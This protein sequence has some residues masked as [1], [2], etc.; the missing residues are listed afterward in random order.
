MTHETIRSFVRVFG[1]FL[2]VA[3]ICVALV[4]GATEVA[5]AQ[6]AT[7]PTSTD[8]IE[9][10][11][12]MVA[13]P[14]AETTPA[15]ERAED[16][17]RPEEHAQKQEIQELFARRPAQELGLFNGIAAG[18]QYAIGLGIPANTIVL[19]LLMPVLATIV[20]FIR[21]IIGL[22]SLEMLVPIVLSYAFVAVGI[23]IGG[24]VLASVV[25]ASFVSRALLRRVPIMIFPKRSLSHLLMAAFVLIA[26]TL[27]L[28]LGIGDVRDLSIFP[29]LILALL[30]DSIVSVQLRKTT[31]ETITITAVTIA[32]GVVGYLLATSLMVRDVLLLYPELVLLLIPLNFAMG[33]YFGLRL[34]EIF[35][36]RALENYGR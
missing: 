16:L 29:V 33:R 13:V 17:T 19:L 6:D 26:L 28:A 7:V 5:R 9:F 27:T 36:F 22:P 8:L 15:G 3:F 18:V 1:A 32:L 31:R 30:G 25:L 35:R 23:V 2:P 10:V 12:N 11:Q 20:T 34:V 4:M 14:P 24:I 21:V